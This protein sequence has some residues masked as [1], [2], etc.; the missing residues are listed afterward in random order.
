MVLN[1]RVQQVIERRRDIDETYVFIFNG[2]PAGKLNHSTWKLAR[3]RA[4]LGNAKGSEEHFRFHDLRTTF[5]TWLRQ[6][7]VGR[8]NLKV[9]LGHAVDDTTHYSRAELTT[10]LGFAERA[11]PRRR[12]QPICRDVMQQNQ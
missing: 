7:G 4:N 6:A 5:A 3:S 9:L 2:H 11:I 12:K 1:S 8:G 10:L